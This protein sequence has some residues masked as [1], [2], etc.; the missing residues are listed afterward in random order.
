MSKNQ[1]KLEENEDYAK[2]QRKI[3]EYREYKKDVLNFTH[4]NNL[5]KIPPEVME[6]DNL[7]GLHLND[8]KIKEIPGFIGNISSLEGLGVGYYYPSTDEREYI[9]LPPELGNLH[10]LR[11]LELKYG[12]KEIPE[13]VWGLENLEYLYIYNDDI[14]TIPSRISNLKKLEFLTICGKN[15]SILP[16]EIGDMPLLTRLRLDCP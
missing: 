14:K 1:K 10:N 13:W 12:V 4:F 7:K 11:Y 5:R 16:D 15:I 9:I 8:T 3:E 6:L 2:A